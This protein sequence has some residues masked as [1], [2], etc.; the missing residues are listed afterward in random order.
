MNSQ[1]T[2][3]TKT[4]VWAG[5]DENSKKMVLSIFQQEVVQQAAFALRAAAEMDSL[6]QN[7]MRLDH[8]RFWANVQLFLTGAANVSKLLW[9]PADRKTAFAWRERGRILRASLN[10]QDGS[11]LQQKGFRNDFEH[12]DERLE[13]W[14]TDSPNRNIADRNI[15]PKGIIVGLQDQEFMRGFDPTTWSITFNGEP[16]DSLAV[17]R[18]LATLH[19]AAS[20]LT[21]QP[22]WRAPSPPA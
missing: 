13:K 6:M 7:R 5:L 11:A 16:H 9:P 8:D 2:A 21:A 17:R 20:R 18:E 3:P 12:F 4:D 19:A 1:G 10:V 15:G 14:L 22:W